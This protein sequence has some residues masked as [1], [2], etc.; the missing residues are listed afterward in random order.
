MTRNAA[1][2]AH[3]HCHGHHHPDHRPEADSSARWWGPAS[4]RGAL[5]APVP[6]GWLERRDLGGLRM[7][8]DQ[9]HRTVAAAVVL[10]LERLRQDAGPLPIAVWEQLG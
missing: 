7:L 4:H 6:A 9:T 3:S 8:N 10:F 1:G 2:W 5:Y